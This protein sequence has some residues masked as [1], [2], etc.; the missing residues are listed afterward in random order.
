MQRRAFCFGWL[1]G[2]GFLESVDNIIQL[3]DDVYTRTIYVH[4]RQNDN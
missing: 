2:V 4:T 3:S 1:V